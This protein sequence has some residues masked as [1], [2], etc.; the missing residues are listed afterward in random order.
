MAAFLLAQQPGNSMPFIKLIKLLY[1]TDKS[2]YD[3]LGYSISG[4]HPVS[5]PHGPVLSQTYD[6]IKGNPASPEA[7]DHWIKDEANY[8]VSLKSPYNSVEDLDELC[9]AEVD[10]LTDVNEKY[11]KMEAFALVDYLHNECTEW[12]D[13]NGSSFPIS[14]ADILKDLGKSNEE[15]QNVTQREREWRSLDQACAS[16]K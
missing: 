6:L 5:M 12:K 8:C 3:T 13:P 15:I 10:L 7:W 14:V 2:G 16:L 11:G 1:L 9:P 4:D